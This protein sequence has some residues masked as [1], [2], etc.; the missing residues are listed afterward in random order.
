[1]VESIEVSRI[2]GSEDEEES[3]AV[4]T[5]ARHLE[6]ITAP[7]TAAHSWRLKERMKTVSVALVLCLNI[8]VDPPDIVKIQPCARLEAWIDPH[9][10][11]PAK[12]IEAIGNSL[13][14]AYERWQPRA[15][16]KKS[17]DPTVEDVTKL[18]MSLRRN[19]KE[20]RVLFHYN[21]HGVP[22]PTTNGEIWVFNKS[23][24][25]YI[26]LSIYELQTWMGAPSI[27]V[28]DCSNAAVIVK[29]FEQ[30]AEQHEEEWRKGNSGNSS[31]PPPSFRQC[32]QLG[33][34]GAKEILPMNP[35]LPADVFTAC[36]T[37]PINMAVRWYLLQNKGKLL[38]GLSLDIVDKIPGQLSDRR[39]LLG[40]LNWIF[41]A[42]TDTIAWNTLPRDLFQKLFR[43]DLLV[44]SLFRNFLLAQRIMRS[45][46]CTPVSSPSLPTTHQ[47]PM[48]DAWDLALEVCLGQLPGVLRSDDP[49]PHVHSPF[50]EEQLTAFQV[51][52]DLGHQHRLP[53]EQ[54]PIVLQVLLSQVHRPRALELLGS[55]LALGPWAVNLVLS[56]GI[57]PYVLRLLQSTARE[58]RPLLVFLWAKILAVD[59]SCKKDLV[60]E[61]GYK[62]FLQVLSDT[63]M[64]AEHRTM[65]AFVLGVIVW[66]H[67]EGQRVVQGSLMPLCLEQVTDP[68][69][70]LRQW[71]TLCLGR[72]WH[73]HPDAR[74][75]ATRDNA[76]EKLYTLLEDP[77]P[78]VRAAA[79][80][81]LG[82]YVSSLTSRERNDHA[83]SID[84]TIA[85]TLAN[86]VTHDGSPLVRQ[87]LVVALQYLIQMYESSFLGVARQYFRDETPHHSNDLSPLSPQASSSSTDSITS[88]P[89]YST[90]SLTRYFSRHSNKQLASPGQ[91]LGSSPDSS[92]NEK[93]HMSPTMG[94]VKRA[95]STHSLSSIGSSGMFS[96]VSS[97]SYHGLYCKLWQT[98]VTLEQDPFPAVANLAAQ[99]IDHLRNKVRMSI[100]KDST[101]HTR[102]ESAPGTPVNR[103]MFIVG[104][105]P[106]SHGEATPP[107]ARS[108]N[109]I[110]HNEEGENNFLKPLVTTE[111][112]EW[113]AKTFI[114]PRQRSGDD[115]PTTPSPRHT[116]ADRSSNSRLLAESEERRSVGTHKLDDQVFVHRNPGPP[117]VLLFHP[118]EPLLTVADKTSVTI[119]DVEHSQRVSH[120]N[121]NNTGSSCISSLAV[122]NPSPPS[123]P[124]TNTYVATGCDDGTVRVW[125]GAFLLSTSSRESLLSD[126]EPPTLLTAFQPTTD[127]NPATRSVG[128]LMSWEQENGTLVIGGD[129]RTIRI[130]DIHAE[131]C[132]AELPTGGDSN[133]VITALHSHQA[134]P[135]IV[136]GFSDGYIRVLDR[137]LPSSRCVVRQWREHTSWV[138]STHLLNSSQ[139]TTKIITG[140]DSG[141]VRLWDVR[142]ASSEQ[143]C[144]PSH[145]MTAMATH[146]NAHLFA[147]GSV[148]QVI[149]V[150]HAS[151]S[152]INTIKYHEG[153]MGARIAPVSCLAFHPRRVLLAAGTTDSYITVYG[154][155]RR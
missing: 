10:M 143:V 56:V 123:A 107:R 152:F 30:F 7:N 21:G 81:S 42:I 12:A 64:P 126:H 17:L 91:N 83:R 90:S 34:C 148:N 43:Q 38:H 101:E 102:V 75:A 86:N 51:W 111:F 127:V 31:P 108:R 62:Y 89:P 147:T 120:W 153:F 154:L 124:P 118:T 140:V 50:F 95:V 139:A 32:I 146:A 29:L 68:H 151:G 105:S 93:V 122:L 117:A 25:Q 49:Y 46:D 113:S 97:L 39:T 3:V 67:P 85:V 47:H 98:L 145:E 149:G 78:E 15:R 69:P 136:T 36:L 18:C 80:F 5:E 20:E 71:A 1:M 11:P 103:P 92:F 84:Q 79:V 114:L 4:L 37:T 70:P 129:S 9:S 16:Y 133:T 60:R 52:L 150:H 22:K 8:P 55:F 104:E 26:P 58:L 44:A 99:V 45:Y 100:S 144:A 6:N 19:A 23:Y 137:R 87:E 59:P 135:W 141:E 61:N 109:H 131:R 40:E 138:I 134:G 13:Q 112:V 121:N 94:G 130:W 106:P 28:Y 66:E 65:A 57:F 27:Y 2:T 132:T 96:G 119:W 142:Q 82:T 115:T 110:N 128:L 33:A 53:P 63:S 35:D 125:R 24:T 76:H 155:S 48:W 116:F 14:K 77:V 74:W 88:P 54:L 41:T 72:T 73:K